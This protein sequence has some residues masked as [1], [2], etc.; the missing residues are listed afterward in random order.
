MQKFPSNN[1]H[2]FLWDHH[3]VSSPVHQL[4]ENVVFTPASL[5]PVSL[6]FS[7]GKLHSLNL[8]VF[9]LWG[10]IL[11]LW[12]QLC[13]VLLLWGSL[14]K[15]GEW[16]HQACFLFAAKDCAI[17]GA[18]TMKHI[19]IYHRLN[20]WLKCCEWTAL[21]KLFLIAF[22]LFLV[23]VYVFWEFLRCI[24][25]KGQHI[26]WE[27]AMIWS[28]MMLLAEKSYYRKMFFS[29]HTLSYWLCSKLCHRVF[30]V[31]TQG[32]G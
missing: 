11:S 32:W 15:Q 23:S 13:I 30:L 2:S 29:S 6:F 19:S 3:I 18:R 28:A 16:C 7:K 27:F 22:S 21:W 14:A 26:F 5:W 12:K 10:L 9:W 20:T 24:S 25:I 1:I 17:P 8:L 31:H 4:C